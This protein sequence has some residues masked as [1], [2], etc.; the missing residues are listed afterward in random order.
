MI[1]KIAFEIY[2]P[3]KASKSAGAK[4]DVP[5]ICARCT[6]ANAFPDLRR[7]NINLD[8]KKSQI[9][10]HARLAYLTHLCSARLLGNSEQEKHIPN[11]NYNYNKW[12]P[13]PS[14]AI[15]SDAQFVPDIA[16]VVRPAANVATRND[17]V[18]SP[19]PSQALKKQNINL[20]VEATLS[21]QTLDFLK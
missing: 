2:W 16:I 3:L 6:R 12:N 15:Q 8:K 9:N 18:V 5:K 7:D 17:E 4:G 14:I 21:T 10:E 20:E 11:Y 1:S 13:L 19:K